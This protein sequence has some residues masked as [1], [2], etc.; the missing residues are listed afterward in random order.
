LPSLIFEFRHGFHQVQSAVKAVTDSVIYNTSSVGQIG[1][2]KTQ[3]LSKFFGFP[4]YILKTSNSFVIILF[5]AAVV[6]I[7]YKL[8][9]KSFQLIEAEK[10]LLI[11]LI[12]TSFIILLVYLTSRNPIWSYHFIG[13]E[14]IALLFIGL[15]VGKIPIFSW[16]LTFWVGILFLFNINDTFIK[17][18]GINPYSVSSLTTKKYIVEK[19]YQDA[20]GE[21]FSVFAYSPAIY[22]YDYDY[23]FSWVGDEI[24]HQRPENDQSRAGF[25][26]LI[27]PKTSKEQLEDFINYRT[28]PKQFK[29][30]DTWEIADG[31]IVVKREKI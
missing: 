3:I 17:S 9:R 2:N 6:S 15:V 25:V 26:Y 11:F 5:L 23:L 27:I 13:M 7:V 16:L 12:S 4:S 1:L 14:V 10:K 8:Y 20:R 28:P 22:T 29:T 18:Q 31:T 19:V 24:Y 30:I 21:P